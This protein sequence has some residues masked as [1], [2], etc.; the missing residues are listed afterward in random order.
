ME[1]STWSAAKLCE[2]MKTYLVGLDQNEDVVHPNSQHQERDHLNHNEGEG[3]P[4]VTEDAQRARHW[5]QHDEDT[6]YAQGDLRIHLG[7][8]TKTR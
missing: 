8:A 2:S 4:S 1:L 7:D 6:R 3:D 5:A